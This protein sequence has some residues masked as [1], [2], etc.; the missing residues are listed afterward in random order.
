MSK[1]I[2]FQS[3]M[4]GLIIIISCYRRLPLVGKNVLVIVAAGGLIAALAAVVCCDASVASG[5]SPHCS[6]LSA[7]GARADTDQPTICEFYGALVGVMIAHCSNKTASAMC[8]H[9]TV[10]LLAVAIALTWV[11]APLLYHWIKPRLSVSA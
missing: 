1:V 4:S 6:N 3:S 8:V 9:L 7:F 10:R 11:L 5:H 2:I